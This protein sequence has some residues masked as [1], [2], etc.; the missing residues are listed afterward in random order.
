MHSAGLVHGDLTANNILF[1][2]TDQARRWSESE[3]YA[4]LGE[5]EIQTL[6]GCPPGPQ[7]PRELVA[8][9]LYSFPSFLEENI[10][11]IDFG[12]SF[13]IKAPPKGYQA[14]TVI[15]YFPRN[16]ASTM[17][18][19]LLLT[20][21]GWLAPFLRFEQDARSSPH[22]SML[23][24]T[25]Q[26]L[27]GAHLRNITSGLREPKFCLKRSIREKLEMIGVKDTPPVADDGPM[28]EAVGMRLE[29]KE[30]M[31]L[32]DL[33]E[34]ILKYRPE[35][36]ITTIREVAQANDN[37]RKLVQSVR[38]AFE[39]RWKKASGSLNVVQILVGKR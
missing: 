5:P 24:L 10:V 2:V 37:D 6:G 22:I 9:T 34:K 19:A 17:L 26:S 30:V 20:S 8:P 25:C 14:S 12:Q 28:I 36:R 11:V 31:L 3:I 13:E 35:E 23:I 32:S 4:M 38:R 29:E 21:G 27:G 16:I 18:L 15:H 7:A 33:L 1:H 39:K